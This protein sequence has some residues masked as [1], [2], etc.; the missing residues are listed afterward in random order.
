MVGMLGPWMSIVDPPGGRDERLHGEVGRDRAL[1][2]APCRRRWRYVL[3]AGQDLAGVGVRSSSGSATT[4]SGTM[5]V[6]SLVAASQVRTPASSSAAGRHGRAR[7]LHPQPKVIPSP[8]PP[9]RG[10]QQDERDDVLAEV[11]LHHPGQGLE[12]VF[13]GQCLHGSS[14]VEDPEADIEVRN[15]VGFL[16][17]FG[18]C[19]RTS[20]SG[21]ENAAAAHAKP[22]TTR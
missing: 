21:W 19:A 12:E 13:T 6:L 22:L 10:A 18:L 15:V 1:A 5:A 2:H 4:S 16:H 14:S 9:W 8:S 17:P 11:R 7:G 3:D 20:R